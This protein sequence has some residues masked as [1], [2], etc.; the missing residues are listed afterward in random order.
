MKFSSI[1]ILQN[2]FILLL[3]LLFIIII[4]FI[5]YNYG[6]IVFLIME[7]SHHIYGINLNP[8]LKILEKIPIRKNL[9]L[10]L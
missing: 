1:I 5:C 7:I 2:I 6:W 8:P 9:N 10:L 4:I 3:Q